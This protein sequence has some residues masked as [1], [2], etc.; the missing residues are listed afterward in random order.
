MKHNK[1]KS[2]S[3]YKNYGDVSKN[4]YNQIES[5]ESSLKT[6]DITEILVSDTSSPASTVIKI[7]IVKLLHSAVMGELHKNGV[8]KTNSFDDSKYMNG[9]N[10]NVENIEFD[11]IGNRLN[12][13]V[14][15]DQ[16]STDKLINQVKETLKQ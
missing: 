15:R 9:L 3:T 5:L 2:M 14:E 16:K 6:G 4:V 13:H 12:V 7:D 10:I 11:A 8:I 1:Q